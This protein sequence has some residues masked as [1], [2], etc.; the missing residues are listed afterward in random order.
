MYAYTYVYLDKVQVAN[1]NTHIKMCV[2]VWHTNVNKKE[3]KQMRQVDMRKY[4][5]AYVNGYMIAF[6]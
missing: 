1:I 3:Q 6:R 5:C 4:V 2:H